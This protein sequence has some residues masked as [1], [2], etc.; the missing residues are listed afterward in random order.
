M[1]HRIVNQRVI[2]QDFIEWYGEG[3]GPP[4]HIGGVGDQSGWRWRREGGNGRS[5]LVTLLMNC[6]VVMML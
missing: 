2:T 5:N 6:N 3:E 1:Y 4:P